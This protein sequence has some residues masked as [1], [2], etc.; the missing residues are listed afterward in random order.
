MH[1]WQSRLTFRIPTTK[2]TPASHRGDSSST[3]RTRLPPKASPKAS[4]SLVNPE[5]KFNLQQTLCVR[6]DRRKALALLSYC[7]CS[8]QVAEKDLNHY[9]KFDA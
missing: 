6:A 1:V 9:I 2:G 7:Q 8:G 5:F 3:G 4:E